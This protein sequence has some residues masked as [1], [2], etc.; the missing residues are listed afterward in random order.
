M[1]CSKDEASSDL[2]E[3]LADLGKNAYRAIGAHPP[4]F[5]QPGFARIA[6]RYNYL[7]AN[8][9]EVILSH[10][11]SVD[12]KAMELHRLPGRDVEF[13]ITNGRGRGCALTIEEEY[14]PIQPSHVHA[15]TDVGGGDNFLAGWVIARGILRKAPSAALEFALE[16]AAHWVSCS[17]D[18]EPPCGSTT[19]SD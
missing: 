9:A 13:C 7:Q 11:D 5:A 14:L 19:C 6:R 3:H 2:L 10:S 15:I 1:P 4:L 8:S 17:H 12:D 18:H 16:A